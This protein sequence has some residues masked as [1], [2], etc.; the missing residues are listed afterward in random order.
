MEVLTIGYKT[1]G[2]SVQETF[3]I[4]SQHTAYLNFPVKGQ[5]FVKINLVIKSS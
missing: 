5:A 4:D 3:S 1:K 2:G